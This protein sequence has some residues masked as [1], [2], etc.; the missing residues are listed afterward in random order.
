MAPW[1]TDSDHHVGEGVVGSWF[2]FEP[3]SEMYA[4]PS[5]PITASSRA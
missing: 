5:E 3:A 4:E 1:M 2:V